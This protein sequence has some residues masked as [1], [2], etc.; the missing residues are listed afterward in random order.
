M[1]T[2][3]SA[4]ILTAWGHVRFYLDAFSCQFAKEILPVFAEMDEKWAA[5]RW[6][7]KASIAKT[8][9]GAGCRPPAER[10]A[11]APSLRGP[12]FRPAITTDQP[13]QQGARSAGSMT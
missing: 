1:P 11:T 10:I 9:E 12:R 13:Q 3:G 4:A 6:F 2:I 5:R 8:V 7:T